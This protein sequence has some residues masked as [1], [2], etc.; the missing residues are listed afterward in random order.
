VEVYKIFL[1]EDEI[2]VR[3]A[4]RDNINWE[5]TDFIF[6]GEAPD[7]E[8]ALPLIEE[9]KPDIVITDIKMPFMDGLELSRI[10]KSNMPWIK[11]II[12]SGHDEFKYAKEAISIN[13]NE[14]ILKPISSADLLKTLHKVA[15][16]IEEERRQRENYQVIN[17]RLKNNILMMKERFLNDL[18]TG[19]IPYAE[20]I[21]K[22]NHFG[23]NI[24]SKY[25]AAGLIVLEYNHGLPG[26]KEY[27]E[28]QKAET[29]INEMLQNNQ[30][31]LK[32]SINIKKIV[33]IFKNDNIEELQRSCY[34]L[35]K[36][37]K[38]EVERNTSC[39]LTF[40]IGSV[41]KRIHG[42]ARSIKD[43]ETAMNFS[44]LF[45]KNK[46]IGVQ[47]TELS[48]INNKGL[49]PFDETKI[50]EYLRHQDKD[51]ILS[52]I[53]ACIEG[54]KARELSSFLYTHM[55][56]SIT[57]AV[58][59]FIEELGGQIESVIPE[60]NNLEGIIGSIYTLD[61]FKDYM[62]K[63]VLDA[64]SF[65]ESKKLNKY[66]DIIHKAKAFIDE[67]FSDSSISLNTVA[68]FVNVS[69]SHF[70]TI[71]SQETEMTFI[72]YLTR[73][74]IEKAKELLKKT[75]MKS[76]EIAYKVGYNDSH[77]FSHVFKKEVGLR[78]TDFRER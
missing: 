43:A 56:I 10:I 53:S 59:K 12:L 61:G 78:P 42:I 4:I 8:I 62:E 18:A 76:S 33:L 38:Y 6:T 45:G 24:I 41:Q 30:D 32:N 20:A 63:I 52:M 26:S 65:R 11:I 77:Y 16:Q 71:F 72:E 70:S 74:R 44:Y 47:D 17:E 13:V 67:N 66:G 31:V 49:L 68:M 58:V 28:Y 40:S 55:F 51:N 73:V 46:I 36:S 2:V 75:N 34:M 60:L 23:I 25:Y 9:V 5:N 14:Y 19:V 39:R 35:A 50:I 7:G 21:K 15:S 3:E 1:V 69:P 29:I 22:A 57:M 27:F 54:I 48:K 64:L 37:I